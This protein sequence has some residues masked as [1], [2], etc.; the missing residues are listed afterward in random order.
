MGLWDFISNH[1]RIKFLFAP[2]NDTM[3]YWMYPIYK[4][5]PNS[6]FIVFPKINE[7]AEKVLQDLKLDYYKYEVGI[8]KQIRP[9]IVIVGNDWGWSE[10]DLIKEC[11]ETRITTVG[12]MEGLCK[13]E[14]IIPY[15]TVDYFFS[16]GVIPSKDLHYLKNKVNTGNPKFDKIKKT[17]F[18]KTQRVLIN[19][20]FAYGNQKDKSHIW[21]GDTTT[22]CKKNSIDFLI[23]K[24]PRDEAKIN[25]SLP[26]VLSNASK[27]SKLIRNSTIV[28]SRSSTIIYEA[29]KAGRI[30]IVYNLF[31]ETIGPLEH[32]KNSH[33]FFK[34]NS[35]TQLNNTL[36]HVLHSLK[37]YDYT[38][39]N[40]EYN[41][42]IKNHLTTKSS[43]AKL[44]VKYL[45]KI[46]QKKLLQ[47]G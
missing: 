14:E 11:H 6:S 46:L 5:L 26:S 12:I 4:N 45:K 28:I 37:N 25:K 17:P 23:A 20:N 2:S 10:M 38:I 29:I 47:S 44:C 7:N 34:T 41:L 33:L 15:K 16:L 13:I 39:N 36:K 43:S 18:P 19:S 9:Q 21:I 24:H 27:I 8:T 32:Q 35:K 40:Q 22:V 31:N 42:F 1:K 30:V 3:V